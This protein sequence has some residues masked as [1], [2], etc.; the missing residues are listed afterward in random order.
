VLEH[1]DFRGQDAEVADVVVQRLAT[2]PLRR[3][4]EGAVDPQTVVTAIGAVLQTPLGPLFGD[5]RLA[6]I[7]RGDRLDELDFDL[8]LAG[9][10]A[11]GDTAV[12]LHDLAEVADA[13]AATSPLPLAA[14]AARLRERPSV[15]VRGF[16]TGSIDLVARIDG[17]YLLADYK[18][19]WLG[20][21]ERTTLDDY[22]PDRLADAMLHGDYLLQASLYLVALQRF[23]RSRLGQRYD[24]DRD[25][26]G[27][28]YLFLRGMVGP[29]TPRSADGTPHGVYA[30]KPPRAYV[31]DLDVVLRGVR[32]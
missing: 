29:D 20:E 32:L 6:D 15:P 11:A 24:Y 27:F 31:D 5:A 25:I 3:P 13:H 12:R 10:Y 16:L 1:V 2:T 19:N 4:D 30:D 9:G 14:F 18:S 7:D 26:A 22:H 17:R 23:L 28:A 21:P 8:P